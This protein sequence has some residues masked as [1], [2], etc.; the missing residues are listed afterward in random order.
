[1]D[2]KEVWDLCLKKGLFVNY[3]D[4]M[5]PKVQNIFEKVVNENSMENDINNIVDMIA[6]E[7]KNIDKFSYNDLIPNEKIKEIDFNDNTVEQSEDIDILL[8]K[9]QKE[10]NFVIENKED[11]DKLDKILNILINYNKVLENITKSQIVILNKLSQI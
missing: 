6:E 11:E 4:S 8:E 10:R 7:L 9:K 3:T 1:M 5:L 2:K